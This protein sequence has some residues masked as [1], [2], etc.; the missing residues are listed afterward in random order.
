MVKRTQTQTPS[1]HQKVRTT[2]MTIRDIATYTEDLQQVGITH[3]TNYAMDEFIYFG[4]CQDIPARLI[5]KRVSKCYTDY[6]P[7]YGSFLGVRIID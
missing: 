5:N 7:N 2:K 3:S 6:H 1:N 4:T